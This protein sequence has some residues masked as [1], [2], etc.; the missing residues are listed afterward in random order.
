[1]RHPICPKCKKPMVPTMAFAYQEYACLP[2]NTM[3]EFFPRGFGRDLTAGEKSGVTR[4]K[5]LWADELHKIG[6]LQGGGRCV[7]KSGGKPCHVCDDPD[8]KFKYWRSKV[9]R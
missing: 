8:F 9:K 6:N 7:K 1:M 3:D 4:R 2:C 5:K